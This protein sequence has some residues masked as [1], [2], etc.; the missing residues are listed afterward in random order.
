MRRRILTLAT[1]LLC[2]SASAFAH[3]L[4]NFTINQYSRLEVSASQVRVRQVLDMAE[5]PAFQE[6]SLIDS[7]KN[8]AA[9]D[10]ELQAYAEK[11]TPGYLENLRIAV[12]GER[13]RFSS[14]AKSAELNDGAGGLKTLRLVWDLL[15]D[16]KS[17][18]GRVAFENLNYNDRIGWNEIVVTQA[19]TNVFDSTA[20]GTA[21]TD[22][23]KAYPS[24]PLLAKLA[25]RSAQFSFAAAVPDGAKTLVN[26][27]GYIATSVPKDKLAE[28]ISISQIT[29]AV[30]FF[31]LL[32]A[33]G[34]GAL[35]AMSPGHGKTV[36][37]AYLIGTRGSAK[38]AAFLGLTVTITHTLGVFALGLVTLFASNYI[39]PE[40]LMPLL[41]FIS[42]LLVFYIGISLFKNRLYSALGWSKP[43][44]HH[45]HEHNH[46]HNHGHTHERDGNT[47]THDGH[48]HSHLPPE[49]ITWRSLL[50]LGV[51]GGLLPCPSALVL[52]LSAISLG[53]VGYGLILT[54][55]F[56]L[57]LAATLTAVG[58]AFLYFGKALGGTKLSNSRVV[59]TLPAFSAFVVACIGA[60]M[61]Y[62]SLA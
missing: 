35:H 11:I 44:H 1:S 19:G 27:D 62:N 58:L 55:V 53:R 48:T 16:L 22:E 51:S 38:H 10:V 13:I 2:L 28:L 42:G 36:V 3:P 30:V 17:A 57:G 21:V 60:I 7:D 45:N 8:G 33:F 46:E 9:S 32:L 52:M 56:S 12:N 47:H 29:P 14:L 59:K 61:A 4:G 40:R 39:V 50:A 18:T 49:A 25:E 5:I 54:V 15:A 26:R 20:Y 37:G 41:S 43:D 34:L 23:L 24:D 31:S 6:F